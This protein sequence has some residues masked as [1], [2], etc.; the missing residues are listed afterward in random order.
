ML[1]VALTEVG[2]IGDDIDAPL[3][4]RMQA[5]VRLIRTND[6][7]DIF[8]ADYFYIGQKVR[9]SGWSVNE[10]ERLQA[11]L[12]NGYRIFGCIYSTAFFYF[13]IPG[14]STALEWF[15]VE[16]FR[17]GAHLFPYARPGDPMTGEPISV[18]DFAWKSVDT[19]RPTLRWQGFPRASDLK[20]AP[21]E[22]GRVSNVRYDRVISR[23]Q[24]LASAE[25]IYQCEGLSD[26]TYIIETSLSP[27]T[28]Y[29]WTV[30][31]L[32]ELDGRERVTEWR[33]TRFKVR[34]QWTATSLLSYRF[35]TPK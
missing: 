8:S 4:L 7:S 16:C 25:I 5:H 24:D 20:V 3:L 10:S 29:Y 2:A 12:Q 30:R 22:M 14:T 23:E 13:T 17:P 15:P 9:L 35:K 34:E 18:G 28:G 32:F 6:N 11:D 19:L 26:S 1:D 21:E 27:D 33:S 31:A